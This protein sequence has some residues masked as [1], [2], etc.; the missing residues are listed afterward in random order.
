VGKEFVAPRVHR[1][2]VFVDFDRDGRLDA[3]VT[4]IGDRIELWWNRS[5]QKHRLQ[6]R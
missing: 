6:L 1:G 3:A 4:T 2:V 5:P